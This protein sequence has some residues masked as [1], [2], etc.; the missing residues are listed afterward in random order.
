ML[1]RRGLGVCKF[2]NQRGYGLDQTYPLFTDGCEVSNCA[3]CKV[4]KSKCAYMKPDVGVLAIERRQWDLEKV[5]ASITF[6]QVIY[7]RDWSKILLIR[8]EYQ[9]GSPCK[10]LRVIT[11]QLANDKRRLKV[12]L[13]YTN[14]G[15]NVRMIMQQ[16]DQIYSIFASSY[17]EYPPDVPI[18]LEG[19]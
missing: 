14:S 16:V 3:D 6:D 4:D 5:V 9:D 1:V 18:I 8:F 10:D 7:D 11:I 19:I 12:L 13:E 2:N 17:A 15:Q